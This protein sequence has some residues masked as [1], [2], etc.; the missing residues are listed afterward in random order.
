MRFG[1]TVTPRLYDRLV[2]RLFERLALAR[3]PSA[4]TSG[5][6]F[7]PSEKVRPVR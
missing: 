3:E 5:N 6:V 4:A 2:G 1:F 7:Q